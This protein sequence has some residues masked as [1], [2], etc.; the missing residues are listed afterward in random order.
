MA[1]GVVVYHSYSSP[2]LYHGKLEITDDSLGTSTENIT[3]LI[4]EPDDDTIFPFLTV[5]TAFIITVAYIFRKPW[6]KIISNF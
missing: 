4:N 3:I 6:L 5:S 2:G 1:E